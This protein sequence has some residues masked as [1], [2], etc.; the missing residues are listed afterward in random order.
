MEATNAFSSVL[1]ACD[2]NTKPLVFI[3]IQHLLSKSSHR[4]QHLITPYNDALKSFNISMKYGLSYNIPVIVSLHFFRFEG[5]IQYIL[6]IF[7]LLPQLLPDQLPSPFPPSFPASVSSSSSFS[8]S[9]SPVCVAQILHPLDCGQPTR[10]R[11]FK[12]TTDS[13]HKLP[14]IP[15]LRVR[16]H[17]TFPSV[18]GFCLAWACRGLV[19][20]IQPLWVHLCK[21]HGVSGKH[22]HYSHLWSLALTVPSFLIPEPWG[23]G[24]DADVSFRAEHSK[25]S[26]SLCWLP[27]TARSFFDEDLDCDRVKTVAHHFG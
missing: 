24:C 5:L 3:P 14:V 7:S 8:F 23:E 27:L 19:L 2:I 22:F 26:Y 10:G 13:S 12:L 20:V 1:I 18:W 25:T 15:L 6:I 16:P 17:L 11:T 9:S 4:F 21:C